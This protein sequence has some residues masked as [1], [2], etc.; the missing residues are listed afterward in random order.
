MNEAN[1]PGDGARTEAGAS[2]SWIGRSWIGRLV[3]A[4]AAG[5]PKKK[6]ATLT[7]GLDELPPPV[8]T[9]VSA[10]QHVGVI[11]I[12]MVYP[13]II[14]RQTGMTPDQ[15]TNMLQLDMVVLAI[16]VFLQ[17]LPRGPIGS[18]FLAPSSFSGVYLAPTL[19]AI[20]IGG[21]P[22]AWGMT[23]FAGLMEVVLSRV[24]WRLRPF[25]PPESAGLV[26]FLVGAI[27]GLAALR[28][29][30]EDNAAGA[31]TAADG[32][33]AGG[34]LAVMV[35]LNIWSKGRLKLF[36]IL[37]GMVMGYF[38]SAAVGLLS[39]Q[40]LV[41]A[42]SRPPFAVPS[43]SHLSWAFDWSLAIPFAVSGLA[44]TMNS[45]AVVTTYQRLTDAE[46]VRPDMASIGRGLLGDGIS[47]AV[48]GLLGTYGLTI[49]S[50]NVGVVAATGVAS[51]LIGF[52]VAAILMIV[53][54]QPALIGVLTI[55]PR[56]VMASAMLFTA[57][58][59]TISGV[60]IISSRVLD[61]RRT[62]VVGMG[63]M[64][65]IVVSVFPGAFASAP[66]WAQPLVTSPL[67]LAMLVALTLNLLFRLGIRRKVEAVVDPAAPDTKEISNFIERNAGVWGARRDV[68]NRVEFAVQQAVE[69]VIDACDVKG[70]IKIEVS[71]DEFVIDAVVT[72]AGA[73]LEFPTRPPSTEEMLET[74]DGHRR[75]AGFLIRRYA[76]RMTSTTSGEQTVLRLYFD[77]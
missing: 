8:V 37:I 21:L 69:A 39:V 65:F 25:I 2:R 33:V 20:K 31:L 24:W 57:V 67:V 10:I 36:C 15:T 71:Y 63:I 46:W 7:Y 3:A 19:L 27:V 14:A 68:I 64:A 55:M 51:R 43:V 48:A 75:L 42:F 11:A 59:I 34:A 26:V 74:E 17:A 6:P 70:P 9:W 60:Q 30:L 32:I 29:L 23:M 12:F 40:D 41:S 52:A 62:L 44:A 72:Y 50:A 76:D 61:G 54:L 38:I 5:V 53:A 73:S 28:L 49:A 56:P 77:H 4:D 18:R 35:G 13:L 22:L 16:A 1:T 66:A 58:F 47:V 45:T